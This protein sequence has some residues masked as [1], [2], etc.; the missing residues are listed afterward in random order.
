MCVCI[1]SAHIMLAIEF[2]A[3]VVVRIP[4]S[5]GSLTWCARLGEYEWPEKLDRLWSGVVNIPMTGSCLCSC[6]SAKDAAVGVR[7]ECIVGVAEF[8]VGYD[9]LFG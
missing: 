4:T 6:A 5:S 8:G 9:V 1:M 7:S 2:N 3:V